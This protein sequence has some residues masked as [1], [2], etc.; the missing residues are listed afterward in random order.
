MANDPITGSLLI[1]RLRM[2]FLCAAPH[3]G[4]QFIIIDLQTLFG[5]MSGCACSVQC[6]GLN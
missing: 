4:R 1:G 3:V 2:P 6:W 5:E